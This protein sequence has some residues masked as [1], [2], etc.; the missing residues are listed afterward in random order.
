LNVQSKRRTIF[1]IIQIISKH[2]EIMI[3][4]GMT[5]GKKSESTMKNSQIPKAKKE[6]IQKKKVYHS[7]DCGKVQRWKF[8]KH[9]RFHIFNFFFNSIYSHLCSSWFHLFPSIVSFLYSI[10]SLYFLKLLSY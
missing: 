4:K 3:E 2:P 5:E 1:H 7:S 8:N 9:T 10:Q 6:K